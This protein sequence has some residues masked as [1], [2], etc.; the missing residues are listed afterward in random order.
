MTPDLAI[1]IV[2]LVSLAAYAGHCAGS[3]RLIK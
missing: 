3:N 1:F 2:F